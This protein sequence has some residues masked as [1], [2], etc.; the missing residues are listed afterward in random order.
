MAPKDWGNRAAISPTQWAELLIQF[1]KPIE[2]ASWKGMDSE[3]FGEAMLP[4]LKEVAK[5]SVRVSKTELRLG[6][7]AAKLS[8][9]PAEQD[10][11]A[12][13]LSWCISYCKRRVRN[14]GSGVRLPKFVTSLLSVW[15]RH[16]GKRRGTKARKKAQ[17]M[18]PTQD[19]KEDQGK[20]EQDQRKKEDQGKVEKDE[21]PKKENIRE[22][23]GLP[24]KMVAEE[25]EEI[26]SSGSSAFLEE[27]STQGAKMLKLPT[28]TPHK[29]SGSS[30]Q[31][32]HIHTPIH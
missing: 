1:T 17:V 5:L 22:V 24:P 14:C 15:Q 25:V 6:L 13:K 29:L 20:L 12:D 18:L 11:F 2:R 26:L 7:T 9:S 31:S 21:D 19:Q 30:R 32:T 28:S 27:V 3:E 16:H 4:L 10:L 8:L 23:F